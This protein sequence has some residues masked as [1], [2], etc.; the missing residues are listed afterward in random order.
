VTKIVVSPEQFHLVTFDAD[1]IAATVERVAEAIGLP[2]QLEVQIEIDETSP[3]GSAR[4]VAVPSRDGQAGAGGPVRLTVQGGALEDAKRPRRLR[5]AS[6]EDVVGR[7]L[8]RALDRLD[9][10]FGN[11]PAEKDLTLAQG[12]AWDAYSVGR[13][14]RLGFGD[15]QARWR[16]HFRNRHGFNDV[17]DGLFDRLWSSTGLTW[18]DLEAACAETEAA[19][20]EDA[21]SS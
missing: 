20:T 6:V 15:T 11:P 9:P 17:A 3:L 1:V 8:F 16:Y 4:L 18:L 14:A 12:A 7:F 13:C 21:K 5:E 10:A 2:A 19:R